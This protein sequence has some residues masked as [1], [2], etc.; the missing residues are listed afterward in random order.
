MWWWRWRRRRSFTCMRVWR[1][2]VFISILVVNIAIFI[3]YVLWLD[4]LSINF[5]HTRERRKTSVGK[6]VA[7]ERVL[8][9]MSVARVI[10]IFRAFWIIYLKKSPLTWLHYSKQTHTVSKQTRRRATEW[11]NESEHIVYSPVWL[12]GISFVDQQWRIAAVSDAKKPSKHTV[13]TLAK[14]IATTKWRQLSISFSL[15]LS[16]SHALC[17]FLSTS[18]VC[19]LNTKTNF[20]FILFH[21]SSYR[22]I[23]DGGFCRRNT[24]PSGRIERQKKKLLNEIEKKNQ[25]KTKQL[26]NT[27]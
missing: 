24:K 27:K 12:G 5:P 3:Y 2:F 25:S 18:F 21:N 26:Q 20:N 6:K 13:P 17:L 8:I 22:S 10:L 7:T 4:K 16:R 1:V 9:E 15:S 19:K 14:L 23:F 11:V